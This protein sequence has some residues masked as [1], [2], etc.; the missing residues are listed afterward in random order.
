M[1]PDVA[2]RA[3]ETGPWAEL[4][5]G[6]WGGIGGRSGGRV[7]WSLNS[8]HIHA[9]DDRLVCTIEGVHRKSWCRAAILLGRTKHKRWLRIRHLVG[10]TGALAACKAALSPSSILIPT[11]HG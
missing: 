2:P 1:G 4:G 8:K 7:G 3:A 10:I 11:G 9:A 5:C 6:P